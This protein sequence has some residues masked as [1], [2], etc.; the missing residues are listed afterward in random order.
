MIR[1]LSGVLDGVGLDHLVLDVGGVGYLVHGSARLLRSLPALGAR[2]SLTVETVVREDAINLY[3]FESATER[4]WFG[5]LQSVQG[6]GAK[7]ALAL[8]G[9]LGPT[10]LA[11]AIAGRDNAALT[12]APGVGRKL[13]E[14]LVTE[15]KD[16]VPAEAA[17]AGNAKSGTQTGAAGAVPT[18]RDAVSAL[19]NLGYRQAEAQAAIGRAS[20]NLGTAAPLEALIRAGLKELVP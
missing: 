20:S 13:A 1:K 4:E 15:L 6:V 16:K 11:S 2:L 5:L 18:A 19:V 17:L 10:A 8:L 3:G 7:V 12:Q 14:R 9:T